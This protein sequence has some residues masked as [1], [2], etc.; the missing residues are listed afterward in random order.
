MKT[1]NKTT[2]AIWTLAILGLINIQAISDNKKLGNTE[3]NT[4]KTENLNVE[5]IKAEDLFIQSAEELTA[6]EADAQ[7]EKFANLQVLLSVNSKD[8]SA[9]LDTAEIVTAKGADQEIEKYARKQ[10]LLQNIKTGK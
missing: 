5:T 10:V 9:F 3:L 7:I 2:I 8:F 1:K 4:A 6:I